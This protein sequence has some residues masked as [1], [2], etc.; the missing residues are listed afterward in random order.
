ML[1]SSAVALVDRFIPAN[2]KS[3]EKSTAETTDET[4]DPE[5]SH[6]L[7]VH[8]YR[9]LIIS[10]IV[11]FYIG[12]Q[13]VALIL[14]E[15]GLQTFHNWEFF[16]RSLF[17][18][19]LFRK[20]WLMP[21]GTVNLN[22][23]QTVLTLYTCYRVATL[24]FDNV[25]R[26]WIYVPLTGFN[27]VIPIMASGVFKVIRQIERTLLLSLYFTSIAYSLYTTWNTVVE[28]KVSW[29]L[30]GMYCIQLYLVLPT[31]YYAYTTEQ[32]KIL[33]LQE[34]QKLLK[35][36]RAGSEAKSLFISNISHDLRTPIH[37]IMGLITLIQESSLDSVQRSYVAAIKSSC[38]HL[39]AVINNV[40]DLSKI[41]KG[42]MELTKDKVDLFAV[43][44]N[45]I[46]TMSSLAEE[47][48]LDLIIDL[49]IPSDYR[50]VMTDEKAVCRVLTNLMGN[51]IKFTDA[52]FVRLGLVCGTRKTSE[53]L[54]SQG[55]KIDY[56]FEVQDSGRGMS[57]EFVDTKIFTPFSQENTFL[58]PNGREGSGLGLSLS[59]SIV[60]KLGSEIKVQST[61]NRGTSF[62]FT[63]PL[64]PCIRTPSIENLFLM[65]TLIPFQI[66]IQVYFFGQKSDLMYR[67]IE[68]ETAVWDGILAPPEV[69]TSQENFCIKGSIT[70][71]IDS[72]LSTTNKAPI[73][74]KKLGRKLTMDISQC[75]ILVSR[76][77]KDAF[78][79]RND[80]VRFLEGGG[81]AKVVSTLY[82]L[83]PLK[84]HSAVSTCV[85][86]IRNMVGMEKVSTL[87]RSLLG[88]VSIFRLLACLL[89]RT[90]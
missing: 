59:Q 24:V 33:L 35:A 23:L 41:E 15:S 39:I 77:R 69:F 18:V 14:L 38:F 42:K 1:I 52:G 68:E 22:H 34:L 78:L 65:K 21:T 76:A 40:I 82:P 54:I 28:F 51:A 83:S 3:K 7:E 71:I 62:S 27:S 61:Y 66:S 47:K 45:V 63:V 67:M 10:T 8:H 64:S 53:K 11:V 44:E 2:V 86:H 20:L 46:D 26:A 4:S 37:A 32:N 79:S 87:L 31:T 19:Y 85:T 9:F 25:E 48:N 30:L 56:I 6:K 80:T 58:N 81:R 84:L 17:G 36:A 50:C 16:T 90:T 60:S 89:Q 13:K 88:L 43:V 75:F 49:K 5:V 55:E 29:G 12:V 74:T 72:E 73:L 70:I 57:Q